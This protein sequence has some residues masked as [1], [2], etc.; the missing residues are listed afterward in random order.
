MTTHSN[1]QRLHQIA[2]D[3]LQAGRV[4]EA[5]AAHHR[6]LEADPALP[7]AWYNLAFLLQQ[8]RRYA[9]ALDSYAKALALGI[10]TPEEVHLN[11]AVILTEHLRRAEEAEQEFLL[12][13]AKNPRYVPALVNL[14]NLYEQSGDRAR[15]LQAYQAALALAPGNALA[16]SRLPNVKPLSGPDDPVFATLRQAIANPSATASDRTDLCFGLGKALDL[17]GAYEEAFAAYTQA[18]RWSRLQAGPAG[19]R[20]DR[21][22]TEQ[23]V[24]RLI[25]AFPA[26]MAGTAPADGPAAPLFICGMFR[27][28]SSLVEQILASHPGVTA[29]GE[30]DLVPALAQQWQASHA[31][32]TM[33]AAARLRA[34]YLAGV[35]HR[36]PAA[37]LLTDKRPDNFLHIGFIKAMFPTAKIVHTRRNPIDNCLSVFFLHLSHTM[38]YAL[39]LLDIAHWYGQY[40]RLMSHWKALFGKDILDVDYDQLVAEPRPGIERLLEFCDLSWDEACLA[41]HRTRSVVRTPSAWQVR[42]PLYTTSSGRWRHYAPFLGEMRAALGDLASD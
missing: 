17:V 5:I 18:N 35:A 22:A 26:P 39:D 9:E 11:R 2:S 1:V 23:G 25:A 15:A 14:G 24:D 42:Q 38:P 36:F 30:L 16:L 41:F 33:D 40:Q 3:L 27:S 21:E 7:D 4:T 8:H 31:P 6:L 13:L 12:A 34:A 19:V 32:L 37:R 20:Y 29:G 10:A 28:G